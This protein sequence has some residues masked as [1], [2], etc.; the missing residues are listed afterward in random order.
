[1]AV[2]KGAGLSGNIKIILNQAIKYE[3]EAYNMY[4]KAYDKAETSSAKDLFKKLANEEKKH[5]AALKKIN[6]KEVEEMRNPKS[7]YLNVCRSLML[8][9]TSELKALHDI[10][11]KAIKKE[12]EANERYLRF[13]KAVKP[14]K[15]KQLFLK[16]AAEETKHEVLLDKEFS[17]CN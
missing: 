7:R 17:K 6:P 15:I 1:M 4:I 2:K 8:T 10:F 13:A 12:K 3:E 11:K 16:L 9:P 14:G 5:K